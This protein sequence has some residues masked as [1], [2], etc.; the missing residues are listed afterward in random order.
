MVSVQSLA[1]L[2]RGASGLLT[3]PPALSSLYKW[4]VQ[5]VKFRGLILFADDTNIF[6]PTTILI[7]FLN[8]EMLKLT[9]WCRAN[10]LS[11]NFKKSNFMVFRPRQRRQTLDISSQINNNVIERV[12]QTVFWGVILD[13]HLSWKPH[14]LTVSRKI[15]KS[16]GIIYKSWQVFAFPKLP[17]ALCTIVYS[18][19]Q[20]NRLICRSPHCVVILFCKRR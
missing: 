1:K 7:Y 16:I 11:I 15:S 10:K 14:I 4:S 2:S 20:K 8:S 6:F 9:Q 18:S 19:L 5:Y 12:K 17:Y 13:E 3:R